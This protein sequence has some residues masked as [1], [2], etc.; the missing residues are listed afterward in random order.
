M[1]EIRL[2]PRI[3][4]RLAELGRRPVDL[5]RDTGINQA[6]IS[7]IMAGKNVNLMTA[8]NIAA[9]LNQRV[10]QIWTIKEVEV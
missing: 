10:E 8:M 2:V 6:A 7:R 3:R 1:I 5:S 9:A 4:E